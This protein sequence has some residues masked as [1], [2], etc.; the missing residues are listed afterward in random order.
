MSLLAVAGVAIAHVREKAAQI[1]ADLWL[2]A[3]AV[4]V[5]RS[6]TPI[7]DRLWVEQ[8][9]DDFAAWEQEASA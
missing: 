1:D 7:F 2:L 9:A 5:V 3:E 6:E 4:D 8:Y